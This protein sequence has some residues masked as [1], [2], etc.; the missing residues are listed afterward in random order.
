MVS[1]TVS[2]TRALAIGLDGADP[3]LL[4]AW[5]ADGTMPCL[6]RLRREG[7]CCE[8]AT[9]AGL[10]DDAVW[11]SFSTGVGPGRHGR[12]FFRAIVSGDYETPYKDASWL[13]REPFWSALA[14]RGRRIAVIDAPKCQ[15][16]REPNVVQVADWRC[17]GRSG[18]PAANPPELADELIRRFGDDSTDVFE[19]QV[20]R[21]FKR[22]L[23]L[24]ERGD[25]IVEL[26]QSIE[27]KRRA[28]E[29]L[30]ARGGWDLF[31]TVFKETHCVGHQCWGDEAALRRVY[32]RIDA[33]LESVI[34]CVPAA[35]PV[36]VF[37]GLAMGPNRSGS[38]LL[39]ALLAAIEPSIAPRRVAWRQ[40]L[41]RLYRG[42]ADPSDDT[43]RA[44]M[45][46][47]A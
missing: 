1:G 4:L 15:L 37:S 8:I 13:K 39:A 14:R 6:A 19:G 27:S 32:A 11:G 25:F 10:G 21:C 40:G 44:R 18:L 26:E 35:T 3:G 36:F 9:P 33:A 42:R 7:A 20:R 34:A 45:S 31:L 46:R 16:A 30:L 2:P 47:I 23:P 43:S 29:E 28:S 5:S 38:H 41:R 22:A 12:Y 17:H 24:A